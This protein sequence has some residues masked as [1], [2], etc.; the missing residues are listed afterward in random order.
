MK[1]LILILGVL[2]VTIYPQYPV[3]WEQILKDDNIKNYKILIEYYNFQTRILITNAAIQIERKEYIYD[4]PVSATPSRIINYQEQREISVQKLK[5]LLKVFKDNKFFLLKSE[6][7]APEDQ[8]FYP[9]Y[10]KL[11]II[12]GSNKFSKEVIFRSNP[13]YSGPPYEF[14]KIEKEI[15]N[16]IKN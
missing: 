10:I 16:M 7:G 13:M 3:K 1:K 9:T 2:G 11:E 5:E 6:Y 14:L 12:D 4:N 8:R 15:L